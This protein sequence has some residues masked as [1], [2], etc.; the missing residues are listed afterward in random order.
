MNYS[1]VIAYNELLIENKK[2]VVIELYTIG[3]G[4]HGDLTLHGWV[5]EH[6]HE[7]GSR[8]LRV[9]LISN[10]RSSNT[11]FLRARPNHDLYDGSMTQVIW[12]LEDTNK[13]I[14]LN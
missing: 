5:V 10:V 11:S 9:P 6:T 2:L 12:R 4:P 13:Q 7:T 14:K 3:Y 8:R 1:I